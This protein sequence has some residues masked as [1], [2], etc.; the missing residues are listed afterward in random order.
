MTLPFY[1]HAARRENARCHIARRHRRHFTQGI[2]VLRAFLQPLTVLILALLLSGCTSPPAPPPTHGD[3]ITIRLW[4]NGWHANI[5]LPAGVLDENHPLRTLFPEKS[6]FL[7][8]WGARDY[9][10]AEKAGFFDGLKAIIPPTPP[11]IHVIAGDNP[12]EEGLWPPQDMV[13]FAISESGVRA[14]GERIAAIISFDE[15]GE[16]IIV[17]EGRVAGA[18]HFLAAKGNFH[19]FNM[20]NHWTARL[21]RDAGVPL[22]PWLSF[23]ASGLLSAAKGTMPATCPAVSDQTDAGLL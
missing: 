9:Y 7:I 10:M 4:S 2:R 1:T 21:L 18:S 17:G 5:A 22:S 19:L 20:C 23:A 16:P 13:E 6:Y 12:V 3:C 15:Q 14:M 8:G 11:A